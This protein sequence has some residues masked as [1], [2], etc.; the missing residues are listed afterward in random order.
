MTKCYL[1]I[2]LGGT[3]VDVGLVDEEGRI[4]GRDSF[5]TEVAAGPARFVDRTAAACQKLIESS[6]IPAKQVLAAGLGSPGPLSYKEGMII[7]AGN[8]PGW[9]GYPI[10]DGISN[11]LGIPVELDND[12]NVA[13]WGEF[14][15]GAGRDI[16][17][18]V[19]FTLGT[20]IGGGIIYDGQIIRG[21]VG[22]GAELG[23]I[24]IQ[25]DGRRC[26]C[27]QNGCVEAYASASHTAARANEA[28]AGGKSSAMQ[29][30]YKQKGEVSCKDVFDF[31]K[32]GDSLANEIVDGTAKALAQICIIMR[33]ITEPQRFVLAGGM[34][35]AGPMLLERIRTFYDQM[36]WSLNEDPLDICFAE[37]GGDA[38][39]VGAA[40]AAMEALRKPILK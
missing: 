19:M 39:V 6:G 20:G 3:N 12:A 16:R 14:W 13:C 11:K 32:K 2:D 37:L 24:I 40:G 15:K 25:P 30:L 10:R 9:G 36:I 31:A 21:S 18:M 28:L 35:K 5:P 22:N 29:E 27:G 34:I 33:H 1:G 38:A 8:L 17:H 26:T 7:D 23:H 4:L